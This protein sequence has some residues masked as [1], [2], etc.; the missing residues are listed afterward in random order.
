MNDRPRQLQDQIGR[1]TGFVV[2]AAVV[3]RQLGFWPT[4]AAQPVELVRWTLLTL[5][6]V[7]FWSAYWR[8]RP[9]IALASNQHRPGIVGRRLGPRG[10]VSHRLLELAKAPHVL[11]QFAQ[12][13]KRAALVGSAG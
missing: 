10:V 4:L 2:F 12:H 9:A 13:E 8:R 7:L 3:V 11:L 6:A 5:L 1:W